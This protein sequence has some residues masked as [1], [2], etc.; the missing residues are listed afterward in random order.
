MPETHS[1]CLAVDEDAHPASS[2]TCS[3]ASFIV[4]AVWTL[5]SVGLGE[6]RAALLVVGAVEPHDERDPR[7]DLVERL[8]QPVRDL[9]AARDAAEDVEQHGL[10]LLVG[11]DDLDRAGDRLG[12]RAA[13]GVEEV[14]R[15][16]AG[17]GDDVE[18]RHHEPG[19]V[20]EDADVAVEL[21]VGQPALARH[22]SCGSS[23]DE[24]AQ[25]GVVRVA[26]QRVVVERDLRVERHR[27]G[28]RP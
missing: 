27:R 23:A 20:A 14:R 2:T 12:L 3:A 4:A 15:L 22:R 18:R 5:G 16:A 17:L 10:D 7:L 13:A 6:E 11:E 8:D 25:L 24:V 1:A 19:A 21:D 9:V 28:G 26:E